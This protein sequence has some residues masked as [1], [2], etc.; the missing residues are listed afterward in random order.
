[1]TDRELIQKYRLDRQTIFELCGELNDRL[2]RPTYRTNSLP[3]SLQICLALR[4][5]ASGCFQSVLADS[6]GVGI[7]SVSRS[8]HSV[9]AELTRSIGDYIKF[10]ET[11]ALITSTKQGFHAIGGFP[12]VIGAVD[13]TFVP[14]IAPSVDEHLYVTRKGFHAINVQGICDSNNMFLNLVVRWPGSTHDAFVWSNSELADILENGNYINCWLLG[15]SA[16]PLKP[17]LLTPLQTPSTLAERRYNVAHKKT[18]CVIERTYGIW[19]MRFRCLHKSS[20]HLMYSPRR[21]VNIICATGV[22]HNKCILKRIPLRESDDTDGDSDLES[23]G[24]DD[25]DFNDT[26]HDNNNDR[27]GRR[28][29]QKVINDTFGAN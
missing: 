8:I 17:Y 5:Y 1:M 27:D 26:Y 25:D 21:S 4:F 16:Y 19:K 28:T 14:I 12:N 6:H 22:L 15:D 3:V 24:D 13:G 7:N 18:R 2:R 23:D 29:R 20:G 11:Q 9:S 10:P